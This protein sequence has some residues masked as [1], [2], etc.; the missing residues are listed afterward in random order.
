MKEKFIVELFEGLFKLQM[1]EPTKFCLLAV[2]LCC[3]DIFYISYII[4]NAYK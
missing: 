4:S 3:C 1:D 2:L